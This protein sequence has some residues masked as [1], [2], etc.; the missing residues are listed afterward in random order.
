MHSLRLAV[1]PMCWAFHLPAI[2]WGAMRLTLRIPGG[3]FQPVHAPAVSLLVPNICGW[4]GCQSLPDSNY[5]PIRGNSQVLWKKRLMHPSRHTCINETRARFNIC[6]DQTASP[7]SCL[8]NQQL[9]VVCAAR[10]CQTMRKR[11]ADGGIG[12]DQYSN[13]TPRI[14]IIK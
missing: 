6:E 1:W 9:T 8:T 11:E 2:V 7:T 3:L 5:R 10:V 14:I 12:A 13:M 4:C